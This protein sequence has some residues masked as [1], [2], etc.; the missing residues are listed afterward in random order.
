MDKAL[1]Q[2]VYTI[3]LGLMLALFVGFGVSTFYKGPTAPEYPSY[4]TEQQPGSNAKAEKLEREKQRAYEKAS[5]KYEEKSK[6]YNRNVSIITL[7]SSVVLLGIGLSAGP[8][9]RT[10]ANGFVIGGLL[11]LG[12]SIIRSL[13]AENIEYTFVSVSIGLLVV[14]YLGY[15]S[16]VVAEKTPAKKKTKKK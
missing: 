3:F 13:I 14:L 7:A 4:V 15:R 2:L 10:I 16:F 8:R 6:L 1:F 12:Y 11:T 5:A 9:N